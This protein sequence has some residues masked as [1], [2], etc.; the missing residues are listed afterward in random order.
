MTITV[1]NLL[2]VVIAIT[3]FTLGIGMPIAEW[4]KHVVEMYQTL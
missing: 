1:K 2:L 3:I 4:F